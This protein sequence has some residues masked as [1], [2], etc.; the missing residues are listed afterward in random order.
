MGFGGDGWNIEKKKKGIKKWGKL[1]NDKRVERRDRQVVKVM[2][3]EEEKRRRSVSYFARLC[4]VLA[5]S[6]SSASS[7][8]CVT[9]TLHSAT[10][11]YKILFGSSCH[12]LIH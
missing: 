11:P 12:L 7:A 9:A 4:L 6:A 8:A 5:A 2:T 1:R 3:E 10:L